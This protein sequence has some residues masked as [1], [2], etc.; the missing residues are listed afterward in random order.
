M[1]RAD[2]IIYHEAEADRCQAEADRLRHDAGYMDYLESLGD[3]PAHDGIVLKKDVLAMQGRPSR[4]IG[5]W[6]HLEMCCDCPACSR[7]REL[8]GI[9]RLSLSACVSDDPPW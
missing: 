5:D 4:Y 6:G 1:S 2:Q 9:E 7:Y 3:G 8:N